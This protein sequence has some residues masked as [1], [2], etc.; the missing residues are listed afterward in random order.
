MKAKQYTIE[1][2]SEKRHYIGN[3]LLK[4][5]GGHPEIWKKSASAGGVAAYGLFAKVHGVWPSDR[6]SNAIDI[7]TA[8]N[9]REIESAEA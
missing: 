3:Y 8:M 4:E 1:S 2:D 7:I 5:N 6:M 9:K